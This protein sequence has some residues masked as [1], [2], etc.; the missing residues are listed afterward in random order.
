M[1]DEREY[2]RSLCKGVSRRQG[3]FIRTHDDTTYRVLVSKQCVDTTH[4]ARQKLEF[5]T[6]I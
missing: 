2:Y 3:Y 1:L 4:V 6:S 5:L